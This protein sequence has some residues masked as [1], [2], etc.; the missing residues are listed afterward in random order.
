MAPAV[1]GVDFGLG[2]KGWIGMTTDKSGRGG[3]GVAGLTGIGVAGL[4]GIGDS[5][6]LC[7]SLS[8]PGSGVD[9]SS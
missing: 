2:I 1:V 6:N 3:S 4:M 5:E 8:R 7:A 9:E